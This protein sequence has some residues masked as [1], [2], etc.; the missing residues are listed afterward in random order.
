MIREPS[1]TCTASIISLCALTLAISHGYA[2]MFHDAILYALQAMSRAE[3]SSLSH[4][5]FLR[6]G[7]QDGFTAFSPIYAEIVKFGGVEPSAA[8][9]TFLMQV[10]LV[11]A[12]WGLARATQSSWMALLGVAAFIAMP[13]DYGASRVFNCIETFCT[14]RMGA[15]ALVLG[16]ITCAMC[17]R[18]WWALALTAAALLIHPIM[19]A[20]GLGA[21]IILHFRAKKRWTWIF[22]TCAGI[23]TLVVDAMALPI[24]R[25]GQFD[26]SWLSL[27]QNRSPY[28]FLSGWDLEAW[29]ATEVTIATLFVGMRLLPD[30]SARIC[31]EV[32]L[33]EA[34]AGLVLTY[35]ACDLM[36]L[37]LFTQL[38]PWRMEWLGVS[39][40]ALMLPSILGALWR[41][42]S[43][44]RATALLLVSAWV[45]RAGE[46][47][48]IAGIAA[49]AC[50]LVS[51]KLAPTHAR[52]LLFGAVGMAAIAVCWRVASNLQFTDT[53]FLDV[54]SEGWLTQTISFCRDGLAPMAVI[55]GAWWWLRSKGQSAAFVI[56]CIGLTSAAA[57]LPTILK[58][59]TR[60]EFSDAS[61]AEYSSWRQLIPPNAEVL[62]PQSPL[63]TWILLG[64]PNYI[65]S[66]QT[67]GMVFSR[68]TALELER[69][70]EELSPFVPPASV[71]NWE[72]PTSLPMRSLEQI[73]KICDSG[74]FDFLVSS[75]ILNRQPVSM[76]AGKSKDDLRALRLYRCSPQTRA[77]AAAT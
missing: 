11:L 20:A 63:Y 45:F 3:P 37:V 38:Q 60:R 54:H 58:Q 43:S 25:W 29:G 21:L 22:L 71:M 4:D 35:L 28:L 1:F 12:A 62:W 9:L 10:A 69:R 59:W 51:A 27:V 19:A 41:S 14:P 2:G 73:E 17:D 50:Q 49:M 26:P 6:L 52:L 44:G 5:V 48:L 31:I 23:A 39:V 56:L 47:A 77:A 16:S 70:A 30:S 55:A 42:A 18:K 36:H 57:V 13:G 33:I 34:V 8:A 61:I 15:E 64:R 76:Q 53:H 74:A 67:S 72:S 65:S 7:S 66:A 68:E 24:G 75:A 46:F 40:A 32:A